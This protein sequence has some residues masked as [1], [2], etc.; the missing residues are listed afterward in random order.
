[1]QMDRLY[2]PGR[3][4]WV[5]RDNSDIVAH[6]QEPPASTSCNVADNVRLYEVLDVEK[7]F[8]QVVFA[9]DMLRCALGYTSG[10]QA[11]HYSK[12]SHASHIRSGVATAIP[13][14]SSEP[15]TNPQNDKYK[16]SVTGYPESNLNDPRSRVVA[17]S[18]SS[19]LRR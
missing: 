7:V 8:G 16:Y 5:I 9:R 19:G 13:I 11:D 12:L 10:N 6:T 15:L 14:L 4:W 17:R 2:P 1:M 18:L 3:V